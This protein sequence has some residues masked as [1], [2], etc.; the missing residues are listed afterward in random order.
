MISTDFTESAM[1]ILTSE[2]TLM[3]LYQPGSKCHLQ[4]YWISSDHN[5]KKIVETVNLKMGHHTR[6]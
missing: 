1:I 6:L 3:K 2:S 4:M 5:N